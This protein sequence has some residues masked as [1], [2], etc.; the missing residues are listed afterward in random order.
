MAATLDVK[1]RIAAFVSNYQLFF[2]EFVEAYFKFN[3]EY[4]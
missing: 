2:G 1:T 3:E 4:K